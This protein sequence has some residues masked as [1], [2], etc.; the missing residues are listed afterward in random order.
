MGVLQGLASG[1]SACTPPLLARLFG[2]RQTPGGCFRALGHPD[3]RLWI[4][5]LYHVTTPENARK[6]RDEGFR[7]DAGDTPYSEVTWPIGNWR[8]VDDA[9]FLRT[10]DWWKETV[11]PNRHSLAPPSRNPRTAISVAPRTCPKVRYG[12]RIRA[13]TRSQNPGKKKCG[14]AIR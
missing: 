3:V 13:S 9:M 10:V 6:I 8:A 14:K 7:A 12:P 5:D 11:T 4:M 1:D 2:L